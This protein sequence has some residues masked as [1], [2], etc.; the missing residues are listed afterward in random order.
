MRIGLRILEGDVRD[1]VVHEQ[2][3]RRDR[4]AERCD[5]RRAHHA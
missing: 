4:V 1:R 5:L 2:R 3:N